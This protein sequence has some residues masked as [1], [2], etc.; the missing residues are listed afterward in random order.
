MSNWKQRYEA[1]KKGLGF[2]N[3]DV[4]NLFDK[5]LNS[6]EKAVSCGSFP[7]YLKPVIVTYETMLDRGNITYK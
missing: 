4:S 2:K 5:N 3:K 1:Y 7:E 6:I